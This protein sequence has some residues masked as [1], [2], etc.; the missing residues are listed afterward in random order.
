VGGA[1]EVSTVVGG[2]GNTDCLGVAF[3]SAGRLAISSQSSTGDAR[4][5]RD[6]NNDGDVND[7]GENLVIAA[8][9]SVCDVR[10]SAGG[11][12]DFVY[13]GAGLTRL[14]DLDD[15]G[16]FADVGETLQ[17]LLSSTPVT[18]VE[19]GNNSWIA[20]QTDILFAP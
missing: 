20:T 7:A 6:A 17:L 11:G 14:R 8:G 19:I 16:D 3:T 15:D 18:A 10:R 1:P 13:G 2:T 5:G 4:L 9:A 12:L